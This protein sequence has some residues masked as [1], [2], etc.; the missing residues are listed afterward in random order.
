M[1]EVLVSKQSI[2]RLVRPEVVPRGRSDDGMVESI[3]SRLFGC[4]HYTLSR[5]FTGAG[6]TYVVCLYC[7][8][9]RRFDLTRWRPEGDFYA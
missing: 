8:M 7:G 1:A 5:P 4:R 6:E 9:R 3:S 2:L